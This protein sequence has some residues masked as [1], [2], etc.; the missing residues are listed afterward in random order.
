MPSGTENVRPGK[1]SASM[2]A[3]PLGGRAGALQLPLYGGGCAMSVLPLV[4][5]LPQPGVS[6]AI[7]AVAV[8]DA[9]I[10]TSA[11]K[12]ESG[13]MAASVSRAR[14]LLPSEAGGQRMDD[15]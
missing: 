13:R 12:R 14:A 1:A 2:T 4:A 5:A 6:V 10:I 8:P 11:A 9:T 3:T 7:V 15:K